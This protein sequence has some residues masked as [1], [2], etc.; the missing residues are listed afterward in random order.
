MSDFIQ[1]LKKAV[2]VIPNDANI[3]LQGDG[4]NLEISAVGTGLDVRFTITSNYKLDCCVNGKVLCN[5]LQ[6]AKAT[7]IVLEQGKHSLIAR[8]G[9]SEL[10]LPIYP[11][12]VFPKFS[13]P[14]G[15]KVSVFAGDLRSALRKVDFIPVQDWYQP[16][17]ASVLFDYQYELLKVVASDDQR[18]AVVKII[19]DEE[20]PLDRKKSLLSKDTVFG[21]KNVLPAQGEISLLL[22]DNGLFFSHQTVGESIGI[23]AYLTSGEFPDYERVIPKDEFGCCD[24][25]IW[26]ENLIQ[27]LSRASLITDVISVVINDDFK[28]SGFGEQGKFKEIVPVL[29]TCGSIDVMCNLKY[30]LQPLNRIEDEK[31]KLKFIGEKSPIVLK[32]K[33]YIYIVM[34]VEGVSE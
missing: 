11:S 1:A 14:I 5:F 28:I 21:L 26:K 33:E 7:D 17:K 25:E 9:D 2:S 31:I 20:K 13:E 29:E 4:E 15:D 32:S 16:F 24:C 30:L 18:L 12:E 19:V 23:F 27:S 34:P 22:T 10:E 3:L 6:S 8:F